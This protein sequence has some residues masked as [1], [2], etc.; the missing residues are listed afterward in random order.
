MYRSFESK[1]HQ[2]LLLKQALFILLLWLFYS[3]IKGTDNLKKELISKLIN[4]LLKTP[5]MIY[6]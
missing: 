4:K 2:G 6:N 5:G 3:K 1:K